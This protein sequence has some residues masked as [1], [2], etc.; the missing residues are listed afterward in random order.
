MLGH[1]LVAAFLMRL[2]QFFVVA[3]LFGATALNEG[4]RFIKRRRK[5][6]V[7]LF[8]RLRAHGFGDR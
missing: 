1:L 5:S 4:F 3:L 6:E 8:C 7:S 2:L